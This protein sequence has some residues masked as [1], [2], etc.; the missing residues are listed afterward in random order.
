[1][2]KGEN[3]KMVYMK[4]RRP[5]SRMADEGFSSEEEMPS[6]SQGGF[7]WSKTIMVIIVV[8]IIVIAGWFIATRK[9]GTGFAG[10][11][12]AQVSNDWQAIFLTNGQVYF[13]KVTG[14]S[15]KTLGLNNIYYLQVVSKPLQQSQTG[16]ADQQSQELTLVKL[17]NEIH[18]PY[19]GMII[20]RDQ[21][22]LTEKLKSDSKVVQAINENIA[23]EKQTQTQN[24]AQ[25]QKK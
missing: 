10:S 11:N 2:K 15:E 3:K 20:N 14:V 18:G 6:K 25:T 7:G 8:I 13:G 4:N 17:G 16:V 1:M 23:K 9:T 24:P 19:D 22:L 12:I 5:I 21:I